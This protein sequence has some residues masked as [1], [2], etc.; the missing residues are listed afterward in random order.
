MPSRYDIFYNG[1]IY[2]I[3]N[4]TL[5]GKL[6]F[7]PEL[8][9]EFINNF[10]YYRSELSSKLRY[11]LFKKLPQEIH[12]DR[13]KVIFQPKYFLVD[14]LSFTLLPNHFHMQ[15]KQIKQGGIIKFMSNISNSLTRYY[16]IKNKRKGPVFL[17]Q[18]RSKRIKSQESLIFV[19]KYIHVNCYAHGMVKAPEDIFFYP[20]SS[21]NSYI[22]L[23]NNLKINT[24]KVMSSFG[25]NPQKYRQFILNN[26]ED[27]K[28]RELT[29]YTDLWLM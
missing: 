18:F 23:V 5:D 14:I 13:W 24:A 7:S 26:A 3:F 19:S 9:E 20:Y 15:I 21:I 11:S 17:P 27:Q 29:K 6:I 2:H 1:G 28:M 25:N 12:Q 4:K 22:S 16:N 8:S 10:C